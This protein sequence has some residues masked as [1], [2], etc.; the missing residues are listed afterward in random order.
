[1]GAWVVGGWVDVGGWVCESVHGWVACSAVVRAYNIVGQGNRGAR[2][3][4]CGS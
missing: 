2:V 1:M 4:V 3:I